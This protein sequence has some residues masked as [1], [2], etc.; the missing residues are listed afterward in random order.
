MPPVTDSIHSEAPVTSQVADRS[1]YK[2]SPGDTLDITVFGAPDLSQKV[3]V[4]G[5]GEAYLPLVNYVH[6]G[7][8]DV[9]EAQV[10]IEIALKRGNFMTSPHA[11]ILIAEYASGVVLMGEVMKPGIYPVTASKGMLFD[12]LTEAGGPTPM[13]DKS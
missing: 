4:T 2:I 7:G 3:R 10:A 6:V 5:N 8:L 1:Y 9:E 11:S 13:R 12:I